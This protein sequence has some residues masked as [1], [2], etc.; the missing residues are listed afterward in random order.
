MNKSKL[1]LFLTIASIFCCIVFSSMDTGKHLEV[2]VYDAVVL[3]CKL[4][5]ARVENKYTV[6][7]QYKDDWG[8]TVTYKDDHYPEQVG[9]GDTIQVSK[10]EVVVSDYDYLVFQSI[11][12]SVIFTIV[13]GVMFYLERSKRKD[14]VS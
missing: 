7:Y 3:S 4:D 9:V 8:R 5:E 14:S 12:T 13:S 10:T 11:I 6:S 1:F 2:K